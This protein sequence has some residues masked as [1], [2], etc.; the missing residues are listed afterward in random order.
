MRTAI[1]LCVFSAAIGSAAHGLEVYGISKPSAEVGMGFTSAGRVASVNVQVGDAVKAGDVIAEQ[2]CRVLDARIKQVAL[3]ATSTVEIDAARAEL[4]QREQELVKISQVHEKGA[5]TDLER[6]RAELE[7]TIGKFR[8]SAS[9]EKRELA[10]YRLEELRAE[11]DMLAIKSPVDGY[12]EK[13]LIEAGESPQAMEP[14]VWIVDCDPL[15]IEAPVPFAAIAEI[16]I[17]D[18]LD[19]MFPMEE[20]PEKGTVAVIS[21]VADSASET[22]L[23]RID[24]PNQRGRKAGLRVRI[25]LP[26]MPD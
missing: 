23:V 4:A 19:V 5:A 22:V 26:D 11:R 2:D 21:R 18:M 9:E 10:S 14:V 24:V 3:E 25:F 15:W 17:G 13:L 7:V 6:E 16:A 1:T 20:T 12:V 8:V